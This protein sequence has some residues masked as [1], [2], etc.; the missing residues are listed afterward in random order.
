MADQSINAK[1]EA[2]TNDGNLDNNEGVCADAMAEQWG[3]EETK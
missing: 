2:L 1:L 3:K